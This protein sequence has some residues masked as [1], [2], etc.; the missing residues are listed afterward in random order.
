[1]DVACRGR[2]PYPASIKILC[3][4][5][6]LGANLGRWLSEDWST[7]AARWSSVHAWLFCRLHEKHP[8]FSAAT[9][10]AAAADCARGEPNG[11]AQGQCSGRFGIDRDGWNLVGFAA[12]VRSSITMAVARISGRRN[13]GYG[14]HLIQRNNCITGISNAIADQGNGRGTRR[15][16]PSITTGICAT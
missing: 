1:M 10:F 2:G 14:R 6:A 9:G 5:H 15:W 8:A 13:E 16:H 11:L 7:S 4:G 12:S 3:A